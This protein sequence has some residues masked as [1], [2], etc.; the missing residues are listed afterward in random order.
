MYEMGGG[1]FAATVAGTDVYK[2][3][4]PSFGLLVMKLTT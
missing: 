2:A 3:K 4:P 1:I